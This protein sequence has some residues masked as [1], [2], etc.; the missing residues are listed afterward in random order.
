MKIHDILN[1]YEGDDMSRLIN[2]MAPDDLISPMD[3]ICHSIGR[4]R[5]SVIL[6]LIE[7]FIAD[8][9]P[10]ISNKNEKLKQAK[11]ILEE[12]R[13]LS[14]VRR[15]NLISSHI[16][17]HDHLENHMP[18]DMELPSIFMSNGYENF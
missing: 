18:D 17:R 8:Q 4:T 11:V 3:Q 13:R 15:Q 10:L 9:I 16:Q 5:T 1:L 6:E 7:N 14:D 12:N 2:F